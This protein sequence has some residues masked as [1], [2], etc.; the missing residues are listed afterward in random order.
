MKH[1]IT[2]IIGGI[3]AYIFM[4]FVVFCLIFGNPFL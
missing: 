2:D 4:S 1:K 3:L